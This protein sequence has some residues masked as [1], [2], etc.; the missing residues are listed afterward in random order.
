MFNVP[1]K[2]FFRILIP[3]QK[4]GVHTIF[5][6]ML[7]NGIIRLKIFSYRSIH[8]YIGD[9]SIIFFSKLHLKSTWKCNLFH[10]CTHFIG[11]FGETKTTSFDIIVQYLI[12]ELEK[13]A[14]RKDAS[15]NFDQ[16]QHL[17]WLVH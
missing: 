2:P 5:P 16:P 8:F 9:D 7:D 1:T 6:K 4:V 12:Y 11:H 10:N 14:K 15:D 17:L 3:Q 13:E